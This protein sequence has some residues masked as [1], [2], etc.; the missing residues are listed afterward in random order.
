MPINVWQGK[1]TVAVLKMS[2]R[3]EIACSYQAKEKL[4][5]WL[6]WGSI[7]IALTPD[8][9]YYPGLIHYNKYTVIFLLYKSKII[10]NQKPEQTNFYKIE[11]TVM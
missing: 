4:V 7:A 11:N 3:K 9:P 6:L 10:R 2:E 1:D 8:I 5:M